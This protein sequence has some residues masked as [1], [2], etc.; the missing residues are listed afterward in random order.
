[1]NLWTS[2]KND[3]TVKAEINKKYFIFE[4]QKND[5]GIQKFK[6]EMVHN[7]GTDCS[8]QYSCAV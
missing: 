2:Q 4:N 1:M 8:N 7:T 6:Y 5:D 3:F